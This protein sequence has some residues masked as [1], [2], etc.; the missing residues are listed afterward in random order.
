M[1]APMHHHAHHGPGAGGA[2]RISAH[3]TFHCLTGCIVGEAAGLAIGV[4]FA[5]GATITIILATCLSYV[6]G[7]GLGLRPLVTEQRKTVLEALRIIWIGEAVS[8][9]VMEIVMNLV[10][11]SV[12]GMAVRSILAWAYWK[13]LIF[14]VPAGFLAAWPVNYWLI[15]RE[16]KACH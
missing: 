4:T 8:I 6:S 7:F 5:L 14:A 11:Y 9:G 2:A 12:G 10:D 1:A 13:G 3:A 15:K 16:L